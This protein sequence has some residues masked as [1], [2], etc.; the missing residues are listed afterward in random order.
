MK[1]K[2]LCCSD[3][4]GKVPPPL[5]EADATAWLHA[6]DVYNYGDASKSQKH[7]SLPAKISEWVDARKVPVFG[8]RGNHDC[9]LDAEFFDKC[10][11]SSGRCFE[12]APGLLVVGLGWC[13]G[14][15]YD[16]PGESEMSE[17]VAEAR[18]EYILKSMPST[19]TVVLTHYPPWLPSVYDYESNH[20]GWMFDCIREFVEEIKPLA[21]VQGHVHDIFGRQFFYHGPGFDTLIVSPGPSGGALTVDTDTSLASFAFAR[22]DVSQFVEDDR[23]HPKFLADEGEE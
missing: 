17:V 4:H 2:M 7:F 8:V 22:L 18:R 12:A 3:T 5:D 15:F 20:E 16:L 9:P 1:Y 14:M 13:G 11:D 23:P 6:G 19:K 10:K 21:V